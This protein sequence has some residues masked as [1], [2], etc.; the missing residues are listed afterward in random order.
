M[1]IDELRQHIRVL[2]IDDVDVS[3]GSKNNVGKL[4]DMSVGGAA[5]NYLGLVAPTGETLVVGQELILIIQGKVTMPGIVARIFDG[6]FA[7]K[8]DFSIPH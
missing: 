1:T 3:Y 2:T 8:F 6:G 5:V 7:T 4:Y